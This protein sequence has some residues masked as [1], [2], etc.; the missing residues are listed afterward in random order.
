MIRETA[1]RHSVFWL[2]LSN[3][4]LGPP[5]GPPRM[6]W[7]EIKKT[8][9]FL[10]MQKD[11]ENSLY[12]TPDTGYDKKE[13]RPYSPHITLCRFDTQDFNKLSLNKD[14]KFDIDLSFPVNSIEIMESTLLRTGAEYKVIKSVNLL[15]G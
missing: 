7:A 13:V 11:L 1:E 5:Q 15:I 4:L 2:T 3:V 12:E 14:E 8:P 10:D 6:V 9:E